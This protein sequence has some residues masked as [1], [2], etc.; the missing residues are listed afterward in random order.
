MDPLATFGTMNVAAIV[1]VVL[2]SLVSVIQIALALGAPLGYAAWGGC[3]GGALPE[4]LGSQAAWP[5][6]LSTR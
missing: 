3:Y 6:L 5:A 1:A 4:K 2:L